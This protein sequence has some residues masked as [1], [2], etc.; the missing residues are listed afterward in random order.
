MKTLGNYAREK[1][2]KMD[3]VT[4]SVSIARKQ[5]DFIDKNDLNF[6]KLIRD[7]L[8]EYMAKFGRKAG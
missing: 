1:K 7:L 8:A 5:A 6:S 2:E 3:N 4:R